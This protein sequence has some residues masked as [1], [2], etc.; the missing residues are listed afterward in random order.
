MR[1][2]AWRPQRVISRDV[3]GGQLGER[4]GLPA[5][6]ESSLLLQIILI[7]ISVNA[8]RGYRQGPLFL[9]KV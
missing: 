7:R 6:Y 8:L 2:R 4:N 9:N 1:I 3:A 5:W